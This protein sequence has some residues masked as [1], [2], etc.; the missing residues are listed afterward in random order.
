MSTSVKE[1][2][3]KWLVKEWP[4]SQL[5]EIER[6]SVNQAYL[7]IDPEVRIRSKSITTN[8]DWN[9][10]YILT[11]KSNGDLTRTEVE[12]ELSAEQFAALETMVGEPYIRKE[13]RKYELPHGLVLEV[14]L[15]DEGTENEFMYAE[16]EF[17][18]EETAKCF[19]MPF[20]IQAEDVTGNPVY[21]MKNY[22]W[23]SRLGHV[24]VITECKLVWDNEVPSMTRVMVTYDIGRSECLFSYHA[25]DLP[26]LTYDKFI[27]LT[28][29][30]ALCLP[31]NDPTI[32]AKK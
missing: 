2:E 22:W 7:S 27:G 6:V 20:G 31:W 21:K 8:K 5:K 3:R 25:E 19:I 13:V 24:P 18:D 15:V 26:G 29:H 9:P 11:I 32:Q 12:M 30:D 14:S 23:M 4:T 17:P 1:I 16:V 10:R 28:R